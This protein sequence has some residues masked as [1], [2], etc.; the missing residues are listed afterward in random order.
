MTFDG[1]S[2]RFRYFTVID[3]YR[4]RS[5]LKKNV[6][7]DRFDTNP[8][9][10]R[11]SLRANIDVDITEST[12]LKT[13]LL[14]KLHEINETRYGRNNIFYPI[15]NTPAAAFPIRHQNGI[16][17]GSSV[18]GANNPVALL[19]DYGHT[20]SMYGGLLADFSL[21]QN[22]DGITEGLSAEVLY[23]FDNIGG[24]KEIS[25][26]EYRYLEANANITEDGTLVTTPRIYGRDSETLGHSQPLKA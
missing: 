3:Y 6:D 11:A 1:G 24:M 17:G 18:Y 14:G 25:S 4:D 10:T 23:S 2:D 13:G 26:K 8:T 21:R 5:M 9:D 20:R 19:R 7:D 16:Y 22:L 12:L 15:Y